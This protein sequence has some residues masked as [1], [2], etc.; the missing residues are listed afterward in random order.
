MSRKNLIL[1][2]VPQEK[3]IVE[4]RGFLGTIKVIGAWYLWQS[5]FGIG[6][7]I[8]LGVFLALTSL[9]IQDNNR[10][11]ILSIRTVAQGIV[12]AIFM[13][14][15]MNKRARQRWHKKYKH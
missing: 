14:N 11:V 5:L 12:G 4:V 13:H 8:A 2:E 3:K 10:M 6:I 15:S 9:N 7:D 1:V